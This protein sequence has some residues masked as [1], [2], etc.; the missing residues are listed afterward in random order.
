[1]SYKT[2]TIDSKKIFV[3][4]TL[5]LDLSFSDDS[6]FSLPNGSRLKFDYLTGLTCFFEF[7]Q[8]CTKYFMF[9]VHCSF[10]F[11]RYYVMN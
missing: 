7:L 4:I 5:Q 2:D 10:L 3:K 6:S 8:T 11:N 1:M 9:I